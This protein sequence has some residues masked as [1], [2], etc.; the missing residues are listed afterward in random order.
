[1]QNDEKL[2]DYLKRV[3][4]DLHQTRRRLQEVESEEQEPIAIVSMS[5]RYPGGVESPEDLWRLVADG[6]DAVTGLPDNR[7]WDLE[8]LRADD[9][10]EPDR[11]GTSYVH[12]GGFVHDAGDFDPGFFGMSPREALGTDPQ[13]RMLLEVTW[14][15]VERAGIDPQSLRGGQIGVFAGSGIQDY[16][17][18]LDTVPDLAE[19]YMTTATA[20]S[21]IS[22]RIA[23]SLGLEGPAVTV[24]TACSS[25]LVALHLATQALRAGECSLALAGGVM[26]MSTPSAFVAFSRQKGLASDGRCK[27]YADSADGTGWA[28]GAGM[29][30]LE[31][32]SD[33]RRNGHPVLAVVRGSAVNQDGA[34]NGLTAPSGPSQQRVVRQ[35]LANAQLTPQQIDVVEGH[36]TGTKL[37]DPIEAQALLATYGQG[38]EAGRPL[39]LGSLKSNI[40]HAQAAAGVGGIIKMV[41][42]IRHGVL[43]RTLHVE[44]PSSHV[45]WSEGDVEL[46]TEAREWP[47]TGRPRRAGVSSFGLS[48]TNAHVILEQPEPQ[49]TL[50]GDRAAKPPTAPHAWL[51]SGRTREALQAQAERLLTHLTAGPGRQADDVD[52]AYSLATT[53]SALE[54]RATVL[55][56]SRSEAIAALEALA[57]GTR[58]ADVTTTTV[59]DG[60]SAFL[61]TGQGAQ[62]LGMGRGLYEAFPVFAEAFDRV[63]GQLDLP[64]TDVVWGGDAGRLE[65]TE[66]AQPALFAFEV[67]L[68]RLLESWGVRPD[69]VAG[70]SVGEIAAAHVAG[71]FSLA[72]AARLVVARGRLM[73][74]L[75][76]GG[77]MVAVQATEDEVRPLLTGVVSIAAVNGPTSVVVSGESEAVE[78]VAGHFTSLGRKSSRLKVSH[79]F[80][81]PL[82]EPMLDDFRAVA[83]SL[84]YSVP[85]LPVVAVGE[86]TDPEYWVRHVRDAVRFKDGVERLVGEGVTRFVEVGP[87][88]VL[89]GLAQGVL[90]DV[91]SVHLIASQRRSQG[92]VAALVSALARVH[93]T[94]G[95]VDWEAFYAPSGA[96]RVELPTYAFQ[97][98]RYWIE[99]PSVVGDVASAGLDAADHPLLGAAVMLADSDG[100]VLTGRLSVAAQPWLADHVVGGSV[101][102]PGTGFVELATRAG[103]QV[104]ANSVQE[105][106]LQAPLVLPERAGVQVQVVVGSPDTSGDRRVAIYTREE[107]PSAE[108]PWTLH[109]EGLLGVHTG[110]AAADGLSVWPPEG[111]EP[112]VTE[113]LYAELAS[114]GLTYGPTFQGLKAA[115][116]KGDE[117]YAE[118]A[119]PAKEVTSA[120]RF[121]L[122][123]AVL[124]A[125]LHAATFTDAFT[126]QGAVLPFA[127]S[128]V[129]LLAAGVAAARVRLVPQGGATFSLTVADGTGAPVLSVGSLAMREISEQ[130]LAAARVRFHESLF[131]LEWAQ[132]AAG[133]AV[134]SLRT[135]RTVEVTGGADAAAVRAATHH[136]LAE[137]QDWLADEHGTDDRLAVVTRGAVA[138]PGEG[139]T[140]LAG[141]AV[142]GLVRTAQLEAPDQ[143]VLVD[144]DA[145]ADSEGIRAAVASGEPQLVVRA[146]AV[147]GARLARV[148]VD[149]VPAPSGFDE[150]STVLVTG[151][152]G[153]LGRLVSR[154][155]VTAY[156]VRRLVLA[157]RRGADAPGVAELV[158]ELTELG[159]AVDPV[160]CDVADRGALTELLARYPV[161]AVVHLAGVLDDGALGSLDPERMD[162]VLRPKAE[163]A[164]LLHELTADRELT[165][166]VM[167]S[168]ATGVLGAP[169]QGNYAAANALLDGLASH[170]RAA[171]LPG[172]SL[173]WGLW[174][175][176]GG[177]AGELGAA[178]LQRMRRSGVSPLTPEQGMELFDAAQGART[179]SATFLPI[180]LD[181]QA[182]ASQSGDELPPIFRQL[183]RRRRSVRR[184]DTSTAAAGAAEAL[185]QR[186]RELPAEERRAVLLETIRTQ[187]A[188]TLGHAGPETVEA[189]RAFNE[190]GFDSL[191]AVEFRT[192]LAETVGIRLPATLI[193]DY[194]APGALADHLVDELL[195]DEATAAAAPTPG[196]ARTE[197]DDPIAIVSMS[198]RFPGG[199]ESPEDLWRLV[200]DGTDAITGLPDN[201]GWDLE[202]LYDPTGERPHT[203]Y[204]REGG[205]LHDAGGFDP[206]FFG[207]SP[208]E[209]ASMDPQQYLLLETSWEAFERAGIDPASLKG[210]T[211]GLFAG[212]MYHD[213]AYNSSTG[214]IASGRVSYTFGFEGP[215]VTVDTACSSSLVA[216]HLAIQ[217]LRSGECSL[218]LA[219]GVAVMATP[220]VFV[221]FSRQGALA[222]DG[223]CRSFAANTGGTGWS[224]GA[225]M[226]LLERLSDARR[227]GHPVVAVVRGTAV[228]QDGASNG[229]TAPNGPSQQRVIRQALA[230]ARLSAAEVDAVEAHG[231]G[232]K[233][234]DPIEAQALLNTYGQER[235]ET[236]EPLWLGSVKSNLGHTQAAA[237]VGGIIKMVEAIRHGVLPKTLHVDE[238]SDQVDWS[239]GEV[240]LLTDAR[241]W[242]ETGRPR[243]AGVSSFGLSGTN[244]HVI[245]EQAPE[246]EAVV[247][248]ADLACVPLLLS[249]KSAGGVSAQAAK[250]L[251]W[252][253]GRPESAVGDVARSL[254]VERVA[255]EHRAVVV[256]AGRA[257]VLSGLRSVAEGRG[258]VVRAGKGGRSAFLFTGQGA[259]RLGMGRGLYEAFPVFAEA[260]DRVVSELGLP[261]VDIVWGG[262][263]GR[264]ERTEFAQPALFAF[265]VAL[266]RLLESWGVRPDFVAGHSVG[267]IAAAHVAGVFSLADA[268]RLVVARGR[269]MQALP[270]GGAMVAVQATE[271]EVRPLLTGVVSIAAVNGPTS[272]V[273]SGES[274]A[275]EAVAGHFTSLGRKS[276]RLKVSHAFHS[277]LMEPMLDDFRA[278][279]ESLSYSVPVLPVVAVGEVTDPEYW[280]RHVRDAVRFKDG[281]ERLVGEG[282]TRFVE[283]GPDGVLTGLAQGVLEDVE[284]VHLIASQRRS[285]GEVAALVSALARVHNTGGGV[286]WEAFYAPS[287]ARR[288]ELP[289]YA[290]QRERF[291]TDT[292]EYLATSWIGGE[293]GGVTD[294]GL[295]TVDHPLLSAAIPSPD[296]GGVVFTGRLTRGAQGWIADHD[297]LGSVLLPGTGFVELALYA[298][299]QTGSDCLEEL[300]LQAPL[301]LPERGG[302]ALQVV[303]EG[304]DGSGRRVV[305]IH[306]RADESAELDLPWTLHA[307]GVLAQLAAETPAGLAEWPPNGAK[308]V[309]VSGAY[310]ELRDRGYAYGPVFQGLRAAWR[311]G[312]EVYAE[313]VLPEQAHADAERFGIHPALLDAAMHGAL[314]DVDGSGDD[315]TVLPFAWNGVRLHAAGAT[316]LRVRITRPQPDSLVLDVADT[317]GRPV[318]SVTSL[319]GRPVSAE[320]LAH[321]SGSS[322]F[323]LFEVVWREPGVV[324]SG[325]AGPVRVLEAGGAVDGGVL[326]GVR[327]VVSGVLAG[328]REWLADESV[329]VDE[330]LVVVTRGAVAVDGTEVPDL[331]GAPVW[332][333]VRA[334]QAENP[335]RIVLV[336]AELGTGGAVVEAAVASG[337]PE[338]ALRGGRVLVPR[339]VAVAP[340]V[341]GE[342]VSFR[343]GGTVLVTGGTSGLGA[344]VAR[345][346]VAV[347]G[348]RR[349]VLTSRRGGDA[350][351]A[352]ELVAELV[353]EGA[354]VEVVACDVA[355][356][357]A[358]AR[359]VAGIPSGHPLTGVVHA[360]GTT[361]NGLLQSL[362]DDRFD[363]VFRPKVDAAWHLH[364]LTAGLD[365]DA[366]MLFASAGGLVLAAGQAN[367]AAANVFLD[368]LAVE[369]RAAGLP[370]TSLA[371]GLWGVSTGLTTELAEAE[372]RMR[373]QGLPALPPAE[374][375]AAFDAGLRSDRATLVPLRV[376]AATIRSRGED[377]PALLRALVRAPARQLARATGAA[378]ADGATLLG[379]RV[380]GLDGADRDRAVLDLVREQVCA[381]LGHAS[382]DAVEPDRA[383]KELGFDS[384]AAVELRNQ[385][386][387]ATGLRLPATLVFDY[388][389]AQAV[390]D[391]IV[392]A[393]AGTADRTAEQATAVRA[394]DDDPIA[395]VAMSCR[396]P[397]GV[398]SPEE[399]WQLVADGTDAIA[400]FP[401]DRGWDLDGVYDPEPGVPGKSYTR[402]GAFLY[403]AGDFDPGFFGIS[404]NEA[405]AMDPQQRLLLETSWE[406]FERAGIDPAALKGSDTGVF[407]GLMYHDY[408]LGVE[409]AMTSGGSLVSGRVSYTFGFEGP[410]VTVD[411]AC[412][413]SLVALHL[414]IQALR[415]GECSLALAGGV[416]VM[417]T[418]GMIVEFSR[419]RGLAPDGRCKSFAAA[420]DGTGWGEGVG[421]LLVERLSD[422]RRNGHPVVA[423]VRGT[424]VNQDGASN[425]LTAPNG[426]SQ[427]RVIRQALAS[428][429]LSAAEVDAVEAHGTGTKLGDPIEAQALLNTY[430][431]ERAAN[432]EPLLI[433]SFKSNV[434]HTQA[435]AGV[436]GIIKMVEAI[437]HGVLPKTLHVDEPSDQV[438]WSEGEVELLTD[439]REW[440]ETG[441]PRRA[442]ISSFGISGTNA[443][444]IIEQ[445]PE[446]EPK[447]GPAGS[448]ALPYVP[449][450]LSAKTEHSLAGQAA[451]L[452]SWWEGRPE[453]AV[454][455]VARSLAV[456]RVAFEHRA[457]VVGA[458]RAEVL[459]GLRS[460][461]EGRGEVVRAGK[462]GRSAFLF[463][464]QGAQRLGMGRGLYEAFPVFAEAFD[465]VV[466]ELG[467]PLADI[468]WG[469]DAGRLERTEF[470][471]PALFAFEVALFRLLESW[472]VRPDFVAGHSVGEI[473]AA[474]VA[475]VFSLADAARLVVARGRLMQALPEGGAMVAVQATEDEVRPLLTGV[476]SIAAVNGPTSVVVSGETGAVE[477]VVSHFTS[478][479]RKTSRLKVSHAFHSPLMEPMLDDFRAVAQSLSYSVPVLPVVAV[480]EVTG[481]EYWVRHVRDAVRFKDGVERLV[482]EGVTRFVEVGP[483]GVLTGLA[484]GVLEDVE[485]V[486][487]IASQ[488][489]HRVEAEALV[490][491]VAG[492]HCAGGGVDWEAFYAPSGARRVELPTYAFQHERFWIEPAAVSTDVTA[493]GLETADHPLLGAVVV[494][495]D[496]GGAVLTGRLSVAAQ[497]WLADHRIGDAVLFPG[498]GFVELAIRAGD[499]VGADT[500]DELTLQAPLVLPERGGVQ[501]QVVVGGS[502]A[503][504]G[505]TVVIRSRAEGDPRLP[506]TAH[507]DGVLVADS[508]REPVSELRQWP[509]AGAERIDVSDTYTRLGELGYGYGPAF[510]GLRALWRSGDDVYAEIALDER[511]GHDAERFGLHPALLDACLHPA[512]AVDA[513]EDGRGTDGAAVLPFTWQGVTLHAAGASAVRVR[514]RPVGE[515]TVALL[516]ADPTGSPVATVR[517]LVSRPVQV[518]RLAA[519]PQEFVDSLFRVEWPEAAVGAEAP[520]VQVVSVPGGTDAAAVRAATHDVLRVLQNWL[521]I[522]HEPD[523]RLAIVTRGA[524]ALPGEDATDLAGAAVWGLVRAAQLGNPGQF[525]LIDLDPAADPASDP[526]DDALAAALASGEPQC[527]VRGTTVHGA[528]LAR[529]P[530]TGETGAAAPSGFDADSTVLITGATG[531]LGKLIARH[532]VASHGVRHLVLAGRRG[533]AA[534]GMA[535]LR[536]DLAALGAKTDVAACDV[537]DREAVRELLA[538]Y[539]VTAVVHLAGVLDDGA[540][541]SLTPERMNRV[542]APKAEAALVL[543]EL[544]AD[545]ELTAFVMFSSAAG[546]LGNAGQGNYSAANALLDALAAHRRARG[547]PGLSLA[548]GLWADDSGMASELGESG[549]RRMNESGVDAIDPDQGL[550]LFD[551]ATTLDD[552]L[553][554]PV[555]FDLKALGEEP[556][557]LPAI[558]HGL[559]AGRR[560]RRAAASRAASHETLRDRLAPLGADERRQAVVDLVREEAAAIL[561]HAHAGAVRPDRAFKDLGFDS[562]SAVEFR[563]RINTATGLRL[564]ATLVFDYPNAQALADHLLADLAP[565]PRAGETDEER[566]RALLRTVPLD[567]LRDEGLLE[568]L[569]ALS[570]GG[571]EA[572]AGDGLD[573]ATDT[574]G[575][576][577]A[578]ESIDAMDAESLI[579]LALDDLDLDG[580]GDTEEWDD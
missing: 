210:S 121:G 178:D 353:G 375:L 228:N 427:Q 198:C 418:P 193:F 395:I 477:A 90:E 340:P 426:P 374:G 114:A 347:H 15:A 172:Q 512:I 5:C 351:G 310:D 277:P 87:D 57:A 262:D 166:F 320:Q 32:L 147:R 442:G 556:G 84:S 128:G 64:L 98:A 574:H 326:S 307:D 451:K 516:L 445:A 372:Q 203:T 482:G 452:L 570:A 186:L 389:N 328:V 384:L 194:P 576:R 13:Q 420:A 470:A 311:R 145:D 286:D 70:H 486:H 410:S 432:G 61:F 36:G 319:A 48:G 295:T 214:A 382:I 471:Q 568:S 22:G 573:P 21:V 54:H 102:F 365:L 348:V 305:R 485:S 124:D 47:E 572:A 215:S 434:G 569:L 376:D 446:D 323:P 306:S 219:G 364:E 298:G 391:H 212:M 169:G 366:F 122:H 268:A 429:R 85:V 441:H 346:L 335:G 167:Y 72:D 272:V 454:G 457:V 192:A 38:R 504:G 455:D 359:L 350:P 439:A 255:F 139:V 424:A 264:L 309:D 183:V 18:L 448:A 82:M 135:V 500:L 519:A 9:T 543:H 197:D 254:A 378:G 503:S 188:I 480:G 316:A 435:A 387:T 144:C 224:E 550:A 155:L 563:N 530:A 43:P 103:I 123:P 216:L 40:G 546:V 75:P 509:P 578:E 533:E 284:S 52:L 173:A 31:K 96:R 63:V 554:L 552:A 283:V 507:A 131:H 42:A 294:A 129:E 235:P 408:G 160:A 459:S 119:L 342:G 163:A 101:V 225:G 333:L 88:G 415:S 164:L 220:E 181:P 496:E 534:E 301:V 511:G 140:D 258:E 472:G 37:G 423:V 83:E 363:A 412:S 324:A 396:Y 498:T 26:V 443:H 185:R 274:E 567:R 73:Q 209:A 524:V 231:T 476:V 491:A 278:V 334:A 315:D 484:Q 158:T 161:D 156:G 285:Q 8:R 241:E 53:R 419:Q 110:T 525:L 19:T 493:A 213:Y 413:S 78:A 368:A 297:V 227:N 179:D 116:R 400:E 263:A 256:G 313:V 522:G 249:A 25:S 109:A 221:E 393:V 495:P 341:L 1:M 23:Y 59:S 352:A 159:A 553:L 205:F 377:I 357:D 207:I 250:L 417:A 558:F 447:Q 271:D 93:N 518:D 544:T 405:A 332:G 414:A 273:V 92:E 536:A 270:E 105:L 35:A 218:A 562:L 259:Q 483:D 381:V 564:P 407:A 314:I 506:W 99:A 247:G 330:R 280:V 12:Q 430:G 497:P 545:R 494:L 234:G 293:V 112:L 208:N 488:R 95:G 74:A 362:T 337:E 206:S 428:A 211:T 4:A 261:L 449:V 390:A 349:L 118:I 528:R 541:G 104:G 397:G 565:A 380:A 322:E 481:P 126:G 237:G 174:A 204:T 475:G 55:A 566:V 464:G 76:E 196:R 356:R 243:R 532:L 490:A 373:A 51:L 379:Q 360:A 499:Q 371:F 187:I 468:V 450:L 111:A 501:V 318:L 279:A 97:H 157:G 217:A 388:P 467:L 153:P 200:A 406:A 561:G 367:Y 3:T 336:D 182:I 108:L 201:R 422:A 168:S 401:E 49:D 66:F 355:D 223:R 120:G 465:R 526:G 34:S 251:S 317:A 403:D 17:Y 456:E 425:G 575:T 229:L 571:D 386:N 245:I 487:L 177:M 505:R 502:D 136:V 143:F 460:V 444:V 489:R 86:V 411:T 180:V 106:T 394:E 404:P 354:E 331:V 132:A 137:L 154:H 146:G 189:E 79:A 433:G 151:A 24:D 308:P 127:W 81:S 175:E 514:V 555:A 529:V 29:L 531:M 321:A 281:V 402:H 232:T 11:S 540:I 195:G 537:T 7:G 538:R 184:G 226:L 149:G 89:T 107:H 469:G 492:F 190:L 6:T 238:P 115:W 246:V 10:A 508:A 462:G 399:L 338:L 535:A 431:Q 479:G 176:A 303:V 510:Q 16:G 521:A 520:A 580:D 549:L 202:R 421:M 560:S 466:S 312:E 527:A 436:G 267:E 65:R 296:T 71:V 28:E 242:P 461:A 68:F 559:V 257:E 148:P 304:P 80:H 542:L 577:T 45:D 385:L 438:D 276:S 345:H 152:T 325:A 133:P 2:L 409:A 165:A 230:S 94:G 300:T 27:A 392:E 62:R 248:G 275:V 252:W 41:E 548:W 60:A 162:T 239:E 513:Q 77:A 244:A 327:S 329:A 440:P 358:V 551:T 69:F 369:R 150:R 130:Q 233:L 266:F 44:E 222:K 113:G 287:G 339:L 517:A 46:L 474:H 344:L 370:A 458:G 539:P 416:A 473:A 343:S 56:G 33:A 269:L 191:T 67:A 547:L 171:G 299:Q 523:E 141:A 14:E 50:A 291:W 290:F 302:V 199:V 39:Y 30:V 253:E 265:E 453:S 91:E 20:A 579:S 463:T 100:S 125:C 142:W 478:L 398:T 236:G 138:L 260:F 515:N 288:V 289:T 361:D 58:H 557:E 134:S 117:V 170:R 437:R 240:E 292:K 282:V 383:F